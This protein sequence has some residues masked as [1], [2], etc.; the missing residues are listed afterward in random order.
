MNENLNRLL[1]RL[2]TTKIPRVTGQ[3][4]EVCG[5]GEVRMCPLGHLVDLYIE[6]TEG[7]HW[8]DEYPDYYVD[9]NH[10]EPTGQLGFPTPA[11]LGMFGLTNQDAYQIYR[12]N[13][14]HKSSPAQMAQFI[15]DRKGL[16]D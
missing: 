5:D 1:H 14:L 13:D 10:E 4:R 7:A 15:R 12:K 3:L 8:V 16:V 6:Q 2:E 9:P 11:M